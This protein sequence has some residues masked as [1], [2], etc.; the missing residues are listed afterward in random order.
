MIRH[1][2]PGLQ[3]EV[4]NLQSEIYEPVKEIVEHYQ[5][6]VTSEKELLQVKEY[7]YKKKY[8]Q[9]I[10][11]PIR[12]N[13]VIL[14]P[15]KKL[16]AVTA[17][18]AELVDALDSKSSGSNTVSVRFRSRAQLNPCKTAP[19]ADLQGF[20]FLRFP[21]FHSF[22]R[23]YSMFLAQKWRTYWRTCLIKKIFVMT[24]IIS[25]RTSKNKDRKWYYLEWGK[26]AGQR[27]ATGI[28]TYTKPKDQIQKNHNK[29]ALAILETKRS[30]MILDRQSINSGYMPQHKIKTNFLDYYEEFVKTNRKLGNRTLENSLLQFQKFLGRDFI[31]AIDITEQLC[32]QFRDYLL[33]HLNGETPAGYF[34]RFK[35]VM[36][37]ATKNGYFRFNPAEDIPAK[38]KPNKRIKEILTEQE[39]KNLMLTPCVNHEVK[40]AFIVSLY[41]G[42][43]WVDV[44]SLIWENIKNDYIE[45]IQ[46][47]TGK[48]LGDPVAP[49]CDA[50]YGSKKEW[51]GLH[52]PY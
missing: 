52:T 44:K 36:K 51:P 48:P 16:L 37:A 33:Q 41:T 24:V 17:R 11:Q 12:W 15:I 42:L 4:E 30:Q 47:K 1:S 31:S 46:K 19:R 6:G 49:C 25:S 20:M 13:A 3:S 2:K 39:Y 7:Y 9:R 18:V 23:F 5:E 29:E 10:R 14:Q 43:R 50:S 26:A 40:K 45:I 32:E 28:F 35:K 27:V 8:L 34:L 22:S 21:H 38:T